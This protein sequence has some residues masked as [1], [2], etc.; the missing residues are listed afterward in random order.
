MGERVQRNSSSVFE[1]AQYLVRIQP[2]LLVSGLCLF[3]SV[4]VAAV[5]SEDEFGYYQLLRLRDLIYDDSR[6]QALGVERPQYSFTGHITMGYVEARPGRDAAALLSRVISR[7]NQREFLK[8]LSFKVTRAELR[9]FEN[10][11]HYDRHADWP[12][13]RF[14]RN[15][16]RTK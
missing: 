12:I 2:R 4:I 15:P 9:K 7:I 5:S 11:S 13:L 8:A 10:M 16:R 3:S 14:I 6:L 1:R